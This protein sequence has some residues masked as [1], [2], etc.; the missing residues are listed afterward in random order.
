MGR[1]RSL[2]RRVLDLATG[3]AKPLDVLVKELPPL[4]RRLPKDVDGSVEADLLARLPELLHGVDRTQLVRR[5]PS[6]AKVALHH[7][8]HD[9]LDALHAALNL[10]L[11]D[12]RQFAAGVHEGEPVAHLPGWDDPSIPR[13]AFVLA[14]SET[15][16]AGEVVRSRVVGDRFEAVFRAGFAHID[17]PGAVPE[18]TV[19]TPGVRAEWTGETSGHRGGAATWRETYDRST[20]AVDVALSRLGP[21][22][23]LE[24]EVEVRLAGRTATGRVG[25]VAA[26]DPIGPAVDAISLERGTIVVNGRGLDA[27]PTLESAS[28]TLEATEFARLGSSFRAVFPATAERWG[29]GA[30]PLPVGD[31]A[32]VSQGDALPLSADLVGWPTDLEDGPLVGHTTDVGLRLIKPR[33]RDENAMYGQRDLREAYAALE[34]DVDARAAMFQCYWAEVATDSQAAIHRE[35]HRRDPRMRLYWGAVDHSVPLPEGAKRVVAGTREWYSALAASKY[36]VKNTEVGT[37]TRLR[38]GQVYLQTFHGQPFKRMG[39]PDFARRMAPWKAQYEATERRSAY[40]HVIALP[41]PEAA[42]FYREAYDWEGPAFDH[43]LPRTDSLLADDADEVRRATRRLL[44]IRDDQ[45]AVLHATTWREDLSRGDNTSA[46]P[47]LLDVKA[48]AE[49]LGDDVVVLQRSHH[50]VARSDQ[51]HGSGGGVVDVTDHPEINDLV[52]ASDLAILDYS[53]VR[54]D[55]AITGKP[56]IFFVPDLEKYEQE[57]RGFLFPFEESAPGP[58]VRDSGELAALVRD[59]AWSSECAEAYAAFNQRFNRFHD[60]HAAERAVDGLLGWD[61]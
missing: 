46:D 38:P 50:S 53:S 43:G 23:A 33:Q 52:L 31:Y 29:R 51:R 22:Q 57:L 12:V 7:L 26:P 35:L 16:F 1:L 2:S 15:R 59:T 25:L 48:L 19:L 42:E 5:L 24:V 49:E 8:E 39:R 21:E 61:A 10:G 41:Y 6:W 40:W 55:Y 58:V 28:V 36:L 4:V 60:G 17:V 20:W 34:V 18:L 37:Y 30:L 14:D 9:D 32:V 44:G 47:G 3:P 56:M 54:F 11:T 13:E 45:V 27:A